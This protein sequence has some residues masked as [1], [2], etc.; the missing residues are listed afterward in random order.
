MKYGVQY[1]LCIVFFNPSASHTHTLCKRH[2]FT[3]YFHKYCHTHILRAADRE[4]KRQRE[5]AFS[6]KKEETCV[7]AH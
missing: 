6:S 5:R 4:A 2:I 7:S 3:P 1:T